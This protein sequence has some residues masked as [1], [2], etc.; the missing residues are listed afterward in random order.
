[1]R[2]ILITLAMMLAFGTSYA[3]KNVLFEEMTGTWCQW[4]PGGIHYGDSLCFTYDNV[5]FIAIH[6]S[7][8]MQNT[9]YA[10]A[11]GL[12]AAPSANIGRRYRDQGIG[13]WLGNYHNEAAVESK[14]TLGIDVAYDEETRT[15][16][17]TMTATALSD[18]NGNYRFG[19]I[20]VEDAV[21]GPAPHYNQNNV[22]SGG[23][24]GPMGGFESM[25]D[26]VP[27]ERIAYDHVGR[28]LLCDYNGEPNS[29]PTS[30]SAGATANYEISATLPDAYNFQYVRIVGILI[31]PDGSIDNAV[32]SDYLNGSATAAPKF[33][34]NARTESYVYL[35]Y[36][37]N[38]F[39]HD[40]DSRDVTIEM[41]EGPDWLTL[42]QYDHKSASLYGVPTQEGS[43]AVTLRIS[44]G[45]Q[46]NEQSFTVEVREPLSATW[47]YIGPRGFNSHESNTF[48]IEQD[49]FG[50]IYVFCKENN[51][52][53]VYQYNEPTNNWQPLGSI[54]NNISVDANNMVIDR[55]NNIYIAF[56]E[57]GASDIVHVMRWNGELW[58]SLGEA[59]PGA[60]PHLTIDNQGMPYL[61]VR[62]VNQS[63]MSAV[64]R[65][66][67]AWAP[68]TGTGLFAP[69]NEYPMWHDMAF[70]S[71]NVP[72]ISYADYQ[73]GNKVK[74]VKLDNNQ[75][76][77][78]GEP[79]ESIYYNQCISISE[80]DEISLA[81][82]TGNS[83]YLNAYRFD[84][85]QWQCTG[86]N[87][88]NGAVGDVRA[89]YVDGKFTIAAANTGQG[90]YLSV[91][92]YDESWN[93]VGPNLC[94]EGAISQLVLNSSGDKI[95]VAFSDADMD[96]KVSCMQ[97]KDALT[98]YPP[99]NLQAELLQNDWVLLT[100]DAPVHSTPTAYKVYRNNMAIAETEALDFTD[101]NLQPGTY[102]YT[103][104]AL[105]ED[106]ESTP[107]G[108]VTVETTLS[109][110]EMTSGIVIYPSL[111]HNTIHVESPRQG[112]LDIYNLNGQRVMSASL[113]EGGN[114]I[115]V[116]SLS[117]GVYCVIANGQKGV[118]LVKY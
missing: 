9:E 116:T 7:D 28:Q 8:P 81:C 79:I 68:V 110:S 38:I 27:A 99:T 19:A 54:S 12:M 56:K 53:V 11:T 64:F 13:N 118:K 32:Q 86:E 58:V 94:S 49:N 34:S 21:T 52:A 85:S 62:D 92:Q 102:H 25:P 37:Y 48:G 90:D 36:L 42:E 75:W 4:C 109:V 47:E 39:F 41:T 74:V 97:Y 87:L 67:D 115:D 101:E 26:P 117:E 72:Y 70:D 5:I 96:G 107:A 30:L 106:G 20:L 91:L 6:T 50:N 80:T 44:D 114:E 65:Y 111:A 104:T 17:A 61:L 108:P 112:S 15:F 35:N 46:T 84:G 16:N 69:S 113:K 40:T 83:Q 43:Y 63:Y 3:Q 71:N 66:N 33:T 82:C 93:P 31:A 103:V 73:N 88:L 29:F 51:S 76:V 95:L 100:W 78:V 98:H 22:Y 10:N 23:N 59:I 105:Y 60:D 14:T 1:M 45:T 57:S 89:R 77:A 2:K 18:M 24:Y 55:F